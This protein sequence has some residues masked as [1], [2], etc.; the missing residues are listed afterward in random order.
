MRYNV[1]PMD[2]LKRYPRTTGWLAF[3]AGVATVVNP[4]MSHLAAL[5]HH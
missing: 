5:V 4:G 2:W 1:V 3:M